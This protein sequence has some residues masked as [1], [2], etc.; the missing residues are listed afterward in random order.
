MSRNWFASE[1]IKTSC[2]Q[3]ELAKLQGQLKVKLELKSFVKA[4]GNLGSQKTEVAVLQNHSVLVQ[5]TSVQKERKEPFKA[6]PK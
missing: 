1:I 4:D 2:L 6:Y 3:K 5:I